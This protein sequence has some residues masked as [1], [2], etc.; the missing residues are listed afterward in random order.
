MPNVGAHMQITTN[1]A[2]TLV[3][4]S[5]RLDVTTVADVRVALHAAVDAGSGPLVLDLSGV[6]V[7][8]ATGLGVLVGTHRRAGRAGRALVLRD[9]SARLGRLL[10][11]SRLD[12]V[13]VVESAGPVPLP[14]AEPSGSSGAA[15]R[16]VVV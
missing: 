9:V 4:L 11:R 3:L 16:P 8:D 6:G 15:A 7:V 12:R 2:S 13:L 5:G 14:R 1:P 10:K